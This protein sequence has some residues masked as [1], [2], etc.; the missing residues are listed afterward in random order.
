MTIST[1]RLVELEEPRKSNPKHSR[2]DELNFATADRGEK[3]GSTIYRAHYPDGE[4]WDCVMEYLNTQ[5]GTWIKEN[6]YENEVPNIN[7]RV[8]SSP[9]PD[10]AAFDE[11]HR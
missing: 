3:D 11:V 2:S 4:D 10:R 5:V 8:Q 1:S 7:W 6:G 9:E